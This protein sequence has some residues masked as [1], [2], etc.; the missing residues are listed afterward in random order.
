MKES[1]Q[2]IE[3]IL[4]LRS[5]MEELRFTAIQG[6]NYT[7]NVLLNLSISQGL[8]A[9]Q[10]RKFIDVEGAVCNTLHCRLGN[11]MPT[12]ENVLREL[13]GLQN[14]GLGRT[15]LE[16]AQA[17]TRGCS[18]T[19]WQQSLLNLLQHSKKIVKT[20]SVRLQILV[21]VCEFSSSVGVH[22]LYPG[23]ETIEHNSQGHRVRRICWLGIRGKAICR[24]RASLRTACLGILQQQQL[25]WQEPDAS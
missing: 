8:V 13:Q 19:P 16:K 10:F 15:L 6:L 17:T 14:G 2:L 23:R 1:I 4:E 24:C 12:R 7:L 21:K 22:Y 3:G 5:G 25:L 18:C 20:V 9:M 11:S